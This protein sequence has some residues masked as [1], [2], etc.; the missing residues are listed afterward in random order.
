MTDCRN[1]LSLIVNMSLVRLASCQLDVYDRAPPPG[2]FAP[3]RARRAAPALMGS[4]HT[5]KRGGGAVF[6][7]ATTYPPFG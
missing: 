7:V 5:S 4:L 6:P 2:P 1:A 3:V